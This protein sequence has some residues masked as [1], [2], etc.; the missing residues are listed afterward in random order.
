MNETPC[1]LCGL[2][3]RTPV[4][5]D[6]AGGVFC[7]HGCGNVYQILVESGTF[8]PGADPSSNPIFA[9]ARSLGIIGLA[10]TPVAAEPVGEARS[11]GEGGAVDD[12]R[13][14]VLR[15]DGMWCSSCAWLV[16]YVLGKQRGVS[17]ADVS[18]LSDS[19]RVTYRPARV[20]QD[21]LIAAV[22]SLGYR[23]HPMG[24]ADTT[25]PRLRGRRAELIRTSFTFF[26]AMNVMMFQIVQYAGYHGQGVLWFLCALA[27]IVFA[28]AFPIFNR[29]VQAARH[30]HATMDTLVALG[31]STAYLYSIQ[32]LVTGHRHVYFD[33]ACM[34][35]G[36]VMVGKFLETGVRAKASDAL[37][38]LY[39]FIP[40]KASVLRDGV[41]RPVAV[42]QLAVGDLFRVRPGERIPA[43]GQVAAGSAGVDESL[44]TGE[45]RPAPKV[46]GDAVT[47]GA[48][49]LG[50]T[51]DV[52]V[53]RV[54]S[55]GALAKIIALVE[56]ALRNKTP[57]EQLADRISR[58]FVPAIIG[59]SLATV[60]AMI[61]TGHDAGATMTRAVAV[62]VIACPC[63]LGIATPMAMAAGVGAAAR[64]GVLIADGAVFE[65]LGRLK[66]LVLDKTGTAT[67]GRFAVRDIRGDRGDLPAL[68]ALEAMSEHPIGRAIVKDID[69]D[70]IPTVDE[71]VAVAGQG[72]AGVVDGVRW[73]AGNRRFAED[74][75]VNVA[76]AGRAD[77]Q[78]IVYWGRTESALSGCVALGDELR[79]G[80]RDLVSRLTGMGIEVDLVSGDS[81][82][83]VDAVAAQLGIANRHAS[84]LPAD[85]AAWVERRKA[86]VGSAGIVGMIG[87]GVNDAPALATADLSIAMATGADVSSRASQITLLNGDLAR[88]PELIDLAALTTRVMRQNLFWA[89]A[90]NIVCVPLAMIGF[91]QPLW[92]AVAMMIS[93][94]SVILNT[95]RLQ[96]V[97]RG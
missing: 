9:Q 72:V 16:S 81:P 93:S 70:Q 6:G 39:T 95:R 63:A 29:A 87:D 69:V 91:V 41:E 14:C 68:V 33:T 19:A 13:Q 3:V 52:R 7:C 89:C 47:G 67:D 73:F 49:V 26:F 58:V 42:E 54:G 27:T 78:T 20:G 34:L 50:G 86:D 96:W 38:S 61:A 40:R 88:V 53:T 48:T 17:A 90:Y 30:G 55:D 71:F 60:A 46:V 79:P 83:T 92:A 22:N 76:Q 37:A 51:L 77:G 12:L 59:L 8:T 85:K 32:Q 23:A 62:L 57:A 56:D 15:V 64:K 11:E 74:N 25:D 65:L 31:A 2:P 21:D 43:D 4:T 28:L 97:V 94:A 1:Y 24:E 10:Q 66:V 75:G 18:F 35:L 36:L 84:A 80:A 45:S 5:V 82:D 44:L